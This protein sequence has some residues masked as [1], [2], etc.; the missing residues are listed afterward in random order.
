[1]RDAGGGGGGGGSS[2]VKG[3]QQPQQSQ[4][5]GQRKGG[6]GGGGTREAAV[7]PPDDRPNIYAGMDLPTAKVDKLRQVHAVKAHSMA[8]S[9]WPPHSSE[10]DANILNTPLSSATLTVSFRILPPAVLWDAHASSYFP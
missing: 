8:V 3:L 7:L 4:Q 9:R 2:V 5:P 1:P 10:L 6:G